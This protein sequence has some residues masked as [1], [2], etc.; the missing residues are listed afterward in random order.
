MKKAIL[1]FI[2]FFALTAQAQITYTTTTVVTGLSNPVAFDFTPDGRI[3]V[4]QKGGVS[5]PATDAQIKVFSS[6]GTLLGTFYDLT[7]SVNSDFERGLLGI[8]V[9]PDYATNNYIYAYYNHNYNSDERIRV[10]RF[11]DSS[12]V[13]INGTLIFDLDVANNIAG[14]HVG[15]NIHFRPSQPNQLYI[16]IGDLAYQS[17]NTSLN[18]AQKLDEPYGKI[19]RINKDG[20]IPTDN[21]FYDDGNAFTGNC[22]WIWSYGHRNSFDFC[23]NPITDSLYCSE[24]GA[25]TWDE[26]DQVVKGG[27]YGWSTC[28]GFNLTGSTSSPCNLA[29]ALNPIEVWG[30]PLPSVT[31]ILF[32]K[33]TGMSEFTNHLLVADN[34]NGQIYDLTL[35]NAPVYN[36]LVSRVQWI[37][38]TSTGGLTTLREDVNGCVWAMKGGYTSNGEIYRVCHAT[39]TGIENLEAGF[40][41]GR[42]VPNP[43]SAS[44]V[45]NYNLDR[46]MQVRFLLYDVSGREIAIITDEQQTAGAHR[47]EINADALNLPAGIY[48]L[49]LQANNQSRSVRITVL[50]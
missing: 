49:T 41:L 40:S 14:N 5:G 30:N 48:Y 21:P 6:T 37:D 16:T 34:D 25:N 11:T 1:F 8:A 22:D 42:A 9:D 27:N 44:S 45:V 46:S 38:L 20:T 47:L 32:Y 43:F 36:T 2:L 28:E 50:H 13:G 24:N 23:F 7:D 4:T 3:F 31:G 19:L 39:T 29:G 26:V 17:S 15:G 12:N 35:G 18:Y 10:V 33:G